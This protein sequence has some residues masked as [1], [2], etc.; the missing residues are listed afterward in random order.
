[1]TADSASDAAE[2]LLATR[3]DGAGSPSVTSGELDTLLKEYER[4]DKQ[5]QDSFGLMIRTAGLGATLF[6]GLLSYFSASKTDVAE[7][8]YWLLPLAF[9]VLFALIFQLAFITV[10]NGFYLRDLENEIARITGIPFFHFNYA[11]TR[12]LASPRTGAIAYLATEALIALALTAIYLGIIIYSY[13]RLTSPAFDIPIE[14]RVLYIA[15][16]S[17]LFAVMIW[18]FIAS[19]TSEKRLYSRW[20]RGADPPEAARFRVSAVRLLRYALVP[21][22]FDLVNK[23]MVFFGVALFTAVALGAGPSRRLFGALLLVFLCVDLL[24]KQATYIWNDVLDFERDRQHPH[25][26]RRPLPMIGS[27]APGKALFLGRT[28]VAVA[29]ALLLGWARG[30]WWVAPLVIVIFLWQAFYDRWGKAGEIR[31]LWV[32]AVGYAERAAGAAL[33]VMATTGVYHARL[34]ALMLLWTVLFAFV[35]LATYWWAEDDY[36]QRNGRIH[37]PTWFLRAGARVTTIANLLLIPVSALVVWWHAPDAHDSLPTLAG[38][39]LGAGALVLLIHRFV[40]PLARPLWTL[41]I[42][43]GLAFA[44]LYGPAHAALWLLGFGAPVLI[45]AIFGGATYE[46]LNFLYLAAAAKG[47]AQRLDRVLFV[48]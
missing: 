7:I 9:S 35:F 45:A 27:A 41:A 22:P 37:R 15:L 40:G 2:D 4:R 44:W 42:A 11:M 32:A 19:Q 33:A 3:A 16:Q 26:R 38:A 1:M 25:K 14:R 8:V 34:L 36:L 28:L 21:R 17:I 13:L 48:K 10:F 29:A 30:Y 12:A 46:E 47:A 18:I 24:A 43:L 31:K 5:A 6:I 39:L 23:G 20:I